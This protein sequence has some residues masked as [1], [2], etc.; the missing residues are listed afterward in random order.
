M[1]G[2]NGYLTCS[3]GMLIAVYK[4]RVIMKRHQPNALLAD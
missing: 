4:A 3:I 2:R 1:E